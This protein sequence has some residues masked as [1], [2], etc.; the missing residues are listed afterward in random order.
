MSPSWVASNDAGHGLLVSSTG[1]VKLLHFFFLSGIVLVDIGSSSLVSSIGGITVCVCM[2]VCVDVCVSVCVCVCVCVCMCVCACVC[3]H[4]CVC[5][6][7]HAYFCTHICVRELVLFLNSCVNM[8]ALHCG[9][10][11]YFT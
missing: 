7:M 4:A 11:N 8:D 3:A 1:D 9:H 10:G 2:F 5:A 6:S